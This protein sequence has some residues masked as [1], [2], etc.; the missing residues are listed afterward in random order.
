MEGISFSVLKKYSISKIKYLCR[1]L[2]SKRHHLLP[3]QVPVAGHCSCQSR[4]HCSEHVF[5]NKSCFLLQGAEDLS[6]QLSLWL[7]KD[8]VSS[9][10]QTYMKALT[11]ETN[12]PVQAIV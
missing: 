10:L 9:L 11:H 6:L 3:V 5:L 8:A 4:E 7:S 2:L 1:E 12:R